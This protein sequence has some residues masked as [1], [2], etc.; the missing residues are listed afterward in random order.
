[1][2]FIEN[3]GKGLPGYVAECDIMQHT[4]C[5]FRTEGYL[6]Q[7]T[8]CVLRSATHCAL[9]VARRVLHTVS[10]QKFVL[11]TTP[12]YTVLHTPSLIAYDS[13]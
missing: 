6:L 1:M 8:L 7:H 3:E 10:M 13:V 4:L 5:V 9:Y 11:H 12:C 2:V